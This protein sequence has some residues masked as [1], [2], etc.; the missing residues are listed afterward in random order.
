DPSPQGEKVELFMERVAE[1]RAAVRRVAGADLPSAISEACSARG[2]RSLAVP[3]D[4]PGGWIPDGVEIRRDPGLS[5]ERLDTVDGV[6]TGCALAVAQTG[7]IV[8]DGGPAQGRR[9]LS[10]LPD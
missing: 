5:N 4:L 2:V 1:Y 7:T 10:L 8:L 9:A 6:L 3:A